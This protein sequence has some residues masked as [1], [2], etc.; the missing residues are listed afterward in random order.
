MTDVISNEPPKP[1]AYTHS[2]KIASAL[3]AM[4]I[5]DAQGEK[6]CD[7]DGLISTDGNP[8]RLGLFWS[9]AQE[10]LYAAPMHSNVVSFVWVPFNCMAP[11]KLKDPSRALK[12]HFLQ[13]AVK[14]RQGDISALIEGLMRAERHCQRKASTPTGG[15]KA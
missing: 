13:I 9:T 3:E 2:M 5:F 15:S 7:W 10:A 6:F 11:G 8:P 12:I 14:V 1:F 4:H